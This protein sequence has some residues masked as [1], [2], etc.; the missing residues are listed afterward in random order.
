MKEAPFSESEMTPVYEQPGMMPGLPGRTI[1]NAP[2]SPK[3][4]VITAI[5]ERHCYYI[6]NMLDAISINTRLIPDN[7]ARASVMDG[8][9]PI[10]PDPNGEKDVFG[11][12]W[13]YDAPTGGSMVRPGSPLFED[14]NDWPDHI[15]FPDVD[16]WDWKGAAERSKE[17]RSNGMFIY[18]STI[19]TGFLER[20]ISFMNFDNAAVALIDEDQKDAVKD[21]FDHLCDMYIKYIDHFIDDFGS[22]I[23]EV[24]DDWGS[25]NS[26]LISEDTL[27]EMIFPYMKRLGD[28]IHSK[29]A[30]FKQ[31]SCGKIE[32]FVPVMIE[33]G[34]D[35]W[36]G[37]EIN[38]KKQL[39][40]D[41]GDKIMVEVEAPELGM[42]ATDEDI[43]AAAHQFGEDYMAE[44]HP[45]ELSAYS[46]L[47]PNRQ[48]MTEALYKESR[49]RYC[50]RADEVA[51]PEP[52]AAMQ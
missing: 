23:I 25:Q 11:V 32:R 3:E 52:A 27:R 2:V 50:G 33:A 17:Y 42:D 4:N 6:C 37:Q 49:I 18:Q 38:D 24:H 46:L 21:L 14:A 16:S 31:H 45:V 36:M 44:G 26:T 5:E 43:Y 51:V 41:Y 30:Y 19:F 47:K 28:H 48:L 12:E 34:V 20:L 1:W 15:Q 10:M 40:H 9:D 35:L 8:E 7:L 22:Q 29:G 13:L 39:V